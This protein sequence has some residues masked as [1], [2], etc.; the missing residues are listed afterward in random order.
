MRLQKVLD[1]IGSP[2]RWYRQEAAARRP[3]SPDP[4]P[5]RRGPQPDE[6]TPWERHV[7]ETVA[8]ACP[9][10]GYQKIALICLRLGEPIPR[11]KVYRIMQEAG[12]LHQRKR[13]IEVYWNLYEDPRDARG[14]LALF[15]E[16]YNVARPHWALA[17]ADPMIAPARVLTPYEV[18]VKGYKVNPPSWSRWVGWLEKDQGLPAEASNRNEVR[19][20]A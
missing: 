16:R 9:W 2:S 1:L 11:R 19:V 10:Y 17:P 14:K 15:H 7:V 4:P 13:R 12:L 8:R 18:Y 3:T 20:S 6:I 5:S